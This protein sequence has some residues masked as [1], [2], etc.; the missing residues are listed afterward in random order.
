MISPGA[1]VRV[2]RCGDIAWV[3]EHQQPDGRWRVC[4][5]AVDHKG[6]AMFSSRTA[7]ENEMVL[8]QDAP[9]YQPGATITHNGVQHAVAADNGDAVELIVPATRRPLRG[10]GHLR[11]PGGNRT[12]IAKADIVLESLT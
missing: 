6:R 9:S 1:I 12:T 11:I 3:V 2:Y 7:S 4:C 8:V 10:G 5:K